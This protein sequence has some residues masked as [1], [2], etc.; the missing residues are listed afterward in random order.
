MSKELLFKVE[1]SARVW[2]HGELTKQTKRIWIVAHG[3]GQ[4]SKYF[5]KILNI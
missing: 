2:T 3:Y 5:I 1:R 4:L